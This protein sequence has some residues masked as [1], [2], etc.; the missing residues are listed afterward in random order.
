MDNENGVYVGNEQRNEKPI[1]FNVFDH[2]KRQNDFI[3]GMAGEGRCFHVN[4][5]LEDINKLY[6]VYCRSVEHMFRSNNWLKLHS[7]RMRRKPFKKE[8]MIPD[9]FHMMFGK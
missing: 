1:V 5:S 8:Y 2:N 4:Q 7:M 6:L 9:E 3:C